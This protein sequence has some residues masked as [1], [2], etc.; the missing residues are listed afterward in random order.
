MK[1]KKRWVTPLLEER[2]VL[3]YLILRVFDQAESPIAL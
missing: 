1:E 2:L 3:V